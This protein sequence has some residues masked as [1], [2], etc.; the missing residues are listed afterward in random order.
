MVPLHIWGRGW[1]G[2]GDLGGTQSH[3]AGGWLG[4][5]HVETDVFPAAR[6]QA[7]VLWHFPSLSPSIL[8][9]AVPLAAASPVAEPV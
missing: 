3:S 7:P 4:L 9:A 6:G 2:W 1:D 8:L 5:A